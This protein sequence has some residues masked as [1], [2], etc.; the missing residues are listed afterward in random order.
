MV[1]VREEQ[2]EEEEEEEEEG[3]GEGGKTSRAEFLVLASTR[4]ALECPC[5]SPGGPGCHFLADHVAETCSCLRDL[6]GRALVSQVLAFQVLVTEEEALEEEA[7]EEEEALAAEGEAEAEA[8]AEEAVE[9][10]V[11]VA[12]DFKRIALCCSYVQSLDRRF[13]EE[14]PES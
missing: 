9:A 11:G 10:L 4:T 2:E 14:A 8:E 1:R 13:R 6:G 12:L 3:Q 5:H 7:L